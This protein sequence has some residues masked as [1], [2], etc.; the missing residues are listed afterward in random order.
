MNKQEF[1]TAL[2]KALSP[3][4]QADL[5][6]RLSFYSEMIDDRMEEGLSQEEAVASVGSIEEIATQILADYPLG[7]QSGPSK[8][9]LKTWEIILLV[10]GCPIWLSL[11]LAAAAVVFSLYISVW[12]VIISLW[13]VFGT[14]VCCT[15][16]V[17]ATA[18][19]FFYGGNTAA[20]LAAL[21]AGIL[22][23]GLSI[24]FFFLCKWAGCG[25]VWVGKH[26]V[27]VI[28]NWFKKEET[29]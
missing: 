27:K 4:P 23:A 15:P 8:R 2:K 13:A 25:S 17:I 11:G 14:L 29:L 22:L 21:G 24:L 20:G 7:M 18:V 9:Q 6:E 26:L 19:P 28:K 16:V 1:L 10:L 5:E 3:L 12:A